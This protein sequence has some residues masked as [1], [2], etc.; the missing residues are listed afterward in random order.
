MGAVFTRPATVNGERFAA[1]DPVPEG[2]FNERRFAQLV[3]LRRVVEDG[4]DHAKLLVKAEVVEPPA[5][6]PTPAPAAEA[7]PFIVP[8]AEQPAPS[9][10]VQPA[11]DG[12]ELPFL[13]SVEDCSRRFSSERGRSNHE[14]RTHK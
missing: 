8:D 11:V 4:S 13:C 6:E 5:A 2:A 12:D 7:S 14:G 3:E 1:G 10:P 9:A